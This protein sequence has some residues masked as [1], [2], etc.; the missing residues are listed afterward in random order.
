[1]SKNTQ[2]RLR[3]LEQETEDIVGLPIQALIEYPA[4]GHMYYC[5]YYLRVRVLQKT[6]WL[7][8]QARLDI[9]VPRRRTHVL[10][11][12]LLPTSTCTSLSRIS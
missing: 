10:R 1:M 12:L 7:P 4:G 2:S 8:I 6:L 9:S 11:L 5:D 3:A